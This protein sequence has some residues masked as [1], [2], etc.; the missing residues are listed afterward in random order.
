MK[1][2][3][4]FIIVAVFL[5][6]SCKKNDGPN[7]K[8]ISAVKTET[9][10]SKIPFD[11]IQIPDFFA[12]Y[13]LLAPYRSEVEELYSGRKYHYVWFDKNG[14]NEIADLFYNKINNLAD[15]GVL[16]KVPY[17]AQLDDIFE[18]QKHSIHPNATTDILI[19]SLYFY[20]ASKVYGGLDS[21]KIK[22]IGWY[23]PQKKQSYVSYL[24]SLIVNPSLINKNNKEVLGE[25]YRLKE[26]LK[27]YREIEKKGEW[28]TISID[29]GFTRLQ[30]GDSTQMIAQIRQKLFVMGDLKT[31]SKSLKYDQEL[32]EGVLNFK[33]RNGNTVTNIITKKNIESMNVSIA[34]RI[35][36]IMV[37]M[38]RC[39]W[40]S[41]DV[42]KA[43]EFIVI[44]IPAFKL[45]FFRDGKPELVSNVV[46]GKAMNKT[47]IFSADMRYIV[48]SP[49]WNVP[50]SIIKNEIKPAM[51]KNSN[52][53]A[54]HNMEWNG[55]NIRQKPGPKNSL[56]LV[57]FLFPN[58]N[59]IYLHDTPSKGLFKEEK[60]AFSHGCIRVEK[61]KE[62]AEAILKY[63]KNWNPKKIEAAMNKGQE[64]W[65]TLKEKI[66]VYIGYFTAWVTNDGEIHFYDDVYNRDETL[67]SLIF[68]E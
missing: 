47:V 2:T 60:R 49:Y 32:E 45:T 38:E 8:S 24:D 40:I 3:S 37:N 36:T 65:Y 48:F 55:G 20:Y 57:K 62:L 14:I 13:P 42:A 30:P 46:V 59:S 15:E 68:E 50:A 63:D 41:N 64:T 23:L 35:K 16:A 12:K 18:N 27:K 26:V 29:S 22:E 17:K 54:E 5:I 43:K 34:Q 44:N 31:D 28:N 25:Y 53:L 19:S 39:R 7:E 51:A 56:G 67:A 61:P 66:P 10:S 52:Y 58:S 4:S 33:K 21:Q 6:F 11:S 9:D 1:K